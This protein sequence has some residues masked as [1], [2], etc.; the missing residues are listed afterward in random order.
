MGGC[1]S[2]LS[3][4][5]QT[6]SGKQLIGNSITQH[7]GQNNMLSGLHGDHGDADSDNIEEGEENLGYEQATE[8]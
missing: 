2:S 6:I 7:R 8:K 5:Q 3:H 4:Q 1:H